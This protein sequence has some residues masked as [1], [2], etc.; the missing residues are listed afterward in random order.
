M[1]KIYEVWMEGYSCTGQSKTHEFIGK[2]KAESFEQACEIAVKKWCSKESF[3]KYYDSENQT[4]WG[5]KCYDN[6]IDAARYF[7]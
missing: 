1:T 3:E 5:C 4:F 2:V 7:G 6:E